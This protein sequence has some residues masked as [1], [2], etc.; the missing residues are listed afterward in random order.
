MK[1]QYLIY[2]SIFLLISLSGCNLF[3]ND[4]PTSLAINE[5]DS[6]RAALEEDN[7]ALTAAGP[8]YLSFADSF[9]Q[10]FAVEHRSGLD[11]RTLSIPM[12]LETASFTAKATIPVNTGTASILFSDGETGSYSDYPEPGLTTGYT[13]SATTIG[14]EVYLIEVETTYPSSNTVVD[15]YMES[16]Y[17]KDISAGGAADG[18]W[19]IDDP[20]VNDSGINN[21]RFRVRLEMLFDDGSTRYETIVKMIFPNEPTLNESGEAENGFAAFDILSSLDYPALAYPVEDPNAIFSSVV[22]YTHEWDE[23]HNFSFWGGSI[24]SNIIGVRYYTEHFVDN[25]T[26]LKGTVVSYEKAISTVVS[27]G[28]SLVE[29]LADLFVGSEHN[30]LAESVFRKEVIF[31]SPSGSINPQAVAMNSIMR[32]HVVDIAENYDEELQLFSDDSLKLLNYDSATYFIPTGSAEEIVD[33]VTGENDVIYFEKEEATVA[34][35]ADPVGGTLP[36]V[37]DGQVPS[38]LADLY[39]AIASGGVADTVGAE[40][41]IPDTIDTVGSVNVYD[42]DVGTSIP[43]SALAVVP[44]I[45]GT[46]EAWVY[47]EK[48]GNW[49]GIVHKGVLA[50][51]SDEELS[52]QFVDNKGKVGFTIVQQGPYK[53]KLVKSGVRLNTGTWYYLAGTWDASSINVFI[54]GNGGLVNTRSTTNTIGVPFDGGANV[55]IGSQLLDVYSSTYGYFGF[56][57]KINGVKISDTAKTEA[58]LLADYNTYKDLTVYW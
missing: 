32:S 7:A 13:I 8:E 6:N 48:H 37:L 38:D 14:T 25:D 10:T 33:E 50:D 54:F 44:T 16:Y 3:N 49:A 11:V 47:V 24:N 45:A 42:G 22:V 17:V 56:D 34:N 39:S 28:G 12:P 31:E 5:L 1:K 21:P 40:N 23:T 27:Q 57:G 46:V 30:V 19:T 41:D 20:I 55:V 18:I 29:Q 53:Y 4:G 2:I 9:M 35:P 58:E 36:T 51:F 43:E 26:R 15:K 52:L